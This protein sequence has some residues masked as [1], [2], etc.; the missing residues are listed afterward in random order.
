LE[1]VAGCREARERLVEEVREAVTG[2][3]LVD[4]H[5]LPGSGDVR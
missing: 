3:Q 4:A 1:R 2:D 5:F